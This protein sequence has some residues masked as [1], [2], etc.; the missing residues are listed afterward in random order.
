MPGRVCARYGRDR[1]RYGRDRAWGIT[2]VR[3]PLSAWAGAVHTT[4]RAR[5]TRGPLAV[6][7][8][9]TYPP[10]TFL[11]S[12]SLC[13]SITRS[14]PRRSAIALGSVCRPRRNEPSSPDLYLRR[15]NISACISACIS[16]YISACISAY[17]SACISCRHHR[18]F[19]QSLVAISRHLP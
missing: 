15:R 18:R 17:I 4:D 14:G 10:S 3:T 1:A 7:K 11:R 9:A 2:L 6:S 19:R 8:V 5:T 16:A 13:S 12:V